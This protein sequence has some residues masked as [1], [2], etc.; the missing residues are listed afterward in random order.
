MFAGQLMEQT[1]QGSFQTPQAPVSSVPKFYD[2][3]LYV[4]PVDTEVFSCDYL[5]WPTFWG[6]YTAIYIDNPSLTPIEKLCHLL[7]DTY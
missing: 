5:R 7:K 3:W 1:Q 6:L 2:L 4:P